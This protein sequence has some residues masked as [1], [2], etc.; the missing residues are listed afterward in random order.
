[1]PHTKQLIIFQA[2]SHSIHKTYLVEFLQNDSLKVIVIHFLA[3]RVEVVLQ[4]RDVQAEVKLRLVIAKG[5]G[6]VADCHLGDVAHSAT[7]RIIGQ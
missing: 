1:M 7:L 2:I 4:N 5:E 6:S 3:D